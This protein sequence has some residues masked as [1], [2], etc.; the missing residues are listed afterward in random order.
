MAF[1]QI[2]FIQVAF[3]QI[4][5]IQVAFIQVAFNGNLDWLIERK[6]Y[7]QSIAGG[8]L[9]VYPVGF[10]IG[11]ERTLGGFPVSLIPGGLMQFQQALG[12]CHIL[13]QRLF[14]HS[15]VSHRF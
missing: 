9:P 10:N 1:I 14:P 15:H 7:G 4:A 8:K 6:V 2:A 3:I 11:A 13:R 12:R 5:F